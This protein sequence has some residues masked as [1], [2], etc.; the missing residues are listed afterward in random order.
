MGS[1]HDVA[2]VAMLVTM[3]PPIHRARRRLTGSPTASPESGTA[4]AEPGV[5]AASVEAELEAVVISLSGAE[6]DR[7]RQALQRLF[8]G[9]LDRPDT[10]ARI[11]HALALFLAYVE[12]P[13]RPRI[14]RRPAALSAPESWELRL[15]AT[16]RATAA[17]V[18]D[19]ARTGKFP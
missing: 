12:A 17:A 15:E 2:H 1:W 19:A 7:L 3:W 8:G 4:A 16:D 10:P 18:R 5:V 14:M 11:E 13:G 6:M 9:A